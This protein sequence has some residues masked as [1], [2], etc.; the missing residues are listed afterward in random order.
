MSVL[1]GRLSA[2]KC[3]EPIGQCSDS[4]GVQMLRRSRIAEQI[5]RDRRGGPLD[6][7]G[8]LTGQI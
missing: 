8:G 4:G 3:R 6:V 2:G 1:G 5:R 7:M